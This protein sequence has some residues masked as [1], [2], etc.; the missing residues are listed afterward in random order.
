MVETNVLNISETVAVCPTAN[1]AKSFGKSGVDKAPSSLGTSPQQGS[2]F[3]E[4]PELAEALGLRA[5]RLKTTRKQ[6]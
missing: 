4:T 1:M 6:A 3:R 5:L 2:R